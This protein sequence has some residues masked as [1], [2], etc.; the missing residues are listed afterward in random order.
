MQ[1]LRIFRSLDEAR[2][3][4]GPAA[5]SIGNFDGVHVGHAELLRR[6][7]ALAHR[8]GARP[9]AL[10]FHPHPATVVAPER[11]PRLLSTPDERSALMAAA[12][13]E[14]VLILPFD[15]NVSALAPRDFCQHVLVETL[16]A[17]AVVVG[18]NFRFGRG[19]TGGPDELRESGLV[20][21][22]LPLLDCRGVRVSSS[23]IRRLLREGQVSHANRLLGRPYAVAGSVVSGAGR[24]ARHTVPTLNLET[25]SLDDATSALPLD[26]VYFTRTEDLDSNRHWNSITNVGFRPTFEGH[27]LTIETFL[28]GSFTPPAPRRIRLEFLRRVREERRFE[29]PEALK[30]QILADAAQ[31]EAFF[32]RLARFQ[33][34]LLARR[35]P[36]TT[37]TPG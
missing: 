16:G 2:G 7:V 20:V 14:Q 4:F 34:A 10:T 35:Q 37:V 22:V 29:S 30:T 32:R 24:G 8:L 6:T 11:V 3:H 9:A 5:L 18:A 33:P 17:R 26:G 36:G 15:R 19:Q 13:I 23:E 21:E 25:G 1:R 12:G 28:L 31:A 27:H